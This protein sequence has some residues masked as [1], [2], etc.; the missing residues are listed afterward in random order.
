M[1]P[2][3]RPIDEKLA[4]GVSIDAGDRGHTAVRGAVGLAR[5]V[6]QND[7]T[8]RYSVASLRFGLNAVRAGIAAVVVGV[9]PMRASG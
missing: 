5:R 9:E 6:A 4:H 2:A 8:R 1:T 3:A 7:R